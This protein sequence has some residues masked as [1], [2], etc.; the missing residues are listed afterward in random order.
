MVKP[1]AAAVLSVRVGTTRETLWD[2]EKLLHTDVEKIKSLAVLSQSPSVVLERSDG[3]SFVVELVFDRG[4]RAESSSRDLDESGN[5]RLIL[6]T[7]E[8]LPDTPVDPSVIEAERVKA[9]ELQAIFPTNDEFVGMAKRYLEGTVTQAEE[10][11]I[12]SAFNEFDLVRNE[13]VSKSAFLLRLLQTQVR[14]LRSKYHD[15][16]AVN[17]F[18]YQIGAMITV[19]R[20]AYNKALEPNNLEYEEVFDEIAEP[21]AFGEESTSIDQNSRYHNQV[22]VQ[23]GNS[24]AVQ[25]AADHLYHKH[26][27]EFSRWL[28]LENGELVDAVTGQA[29]P[30]VGA[31]S[32]IV[33][34]GHG[35][36][37]TGERLT[38]G[39]FRAPQLAELL[40]DQAVDSADAVGR[41]S[42]V[43][44]GVDKNGNPLT[45]EQFATQLMQHLEGEDLQ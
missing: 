28:K 32:R 45:V 21:D 6:G 22:I 11:A 40:A 13:S 39:G 27:P 34:V 19:Y 41:I 8:P 4:L 7:S 30:V 33:V 38:L 9:E 43:A 1:L 44:C 29:V 31:N 5:F 23:L 37:A 2:G 18:S 12:E 14:N 10:A 20:E 24:D 3:A 16:P 35:G 17:S 15:S 25:S 36:E 42:L 26:S